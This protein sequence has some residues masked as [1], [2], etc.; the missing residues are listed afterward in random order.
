M[1]FVHCHPTISMPNQE[2]Q[3]PSTEPCKIGVLSYVEQPLLLPSYVRKETFGSHCKEE[4]T[5]ARWE[6]IA[7]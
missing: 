6:L 3:P 5:E 2:S 7:S 4:K 1:S